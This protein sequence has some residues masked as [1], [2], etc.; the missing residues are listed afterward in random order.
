MTLEE[1]QW[2]LVFKRS[3]VQKK[4]GGSTSSLGGEKPKTKKNLTRWKIYVS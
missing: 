4:G 2:I 3:I 1:G